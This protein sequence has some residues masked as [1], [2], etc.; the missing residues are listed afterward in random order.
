MFLPCPVLQ[1]LWGHWHPYR[2]S[3]LLC[4]EW[5]WAPLSSLDQKNFMATTDHLSVLLPLFIALLILVMGGLPQAVQI[6]SKLTAHPE[7]FPF[8]PNMFLICWLQTLSCSLFLASS[9]LFLRRWPG[10][11]QSR[12]PPADPCDSMVP[13]TRPTVLRDDGHILCSFKIMLI[14]F[15]Q[16]CKGR[17]VFPCWTHRW[18]SD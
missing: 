13:S 5:V 1:R 17:A 18:Q 10:G 15:V 3:P 12:V 16:R 14:S 8:P 2:E 9:G 11:T 4:R 6:N 7:N